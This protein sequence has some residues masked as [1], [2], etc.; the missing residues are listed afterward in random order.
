MIPWKQSQ[1]GI[2]TA[3][4]TTVNISGNIPLSWF[5]AGYFY[6]I[7]FLI[8]TDTATRSQSSHFGLYGSVIK[9]KSDEGGL[10]WLQCTFFS[11]HSV[12]CAVL[13]L[14]SH[15]LITRPKITSYLSTTG[16]EL[17]PFSPF[18]LLN[19]S[20]MCLGAFLWN[21]KPAHAEVSDTFSS[22]TADFLCLKYHVFVTV[23]ACMRVCVCVKNLF[24]CQRLPPH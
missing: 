18:L 14:I 24:H 2:P 17:I 5:L 1:R 16:R 4:A 8:V 7:L 22:A 20:L 10:I 9:A 11:C 19:G 23:R 15:Q 12:F 13:K 6:F 3:P 21:K